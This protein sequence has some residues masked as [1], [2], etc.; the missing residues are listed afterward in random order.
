MDDGK[1]VFVGKKAL[2]P[3]FKRSSVIEP[4]LLQEQENHDNEIMAIHDSW[5]F[6]RQ[7]DVFFNNGQYDNAISSY[8]KALQASKGDES[9]FGMALIKAYEKMHRYDEALALLDEIESKYYKNEYGIQRAE[10]I[11]TRLT[12]AKGEFN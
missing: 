9:Y 5:A 6:A 4:K 1:G 12:T 7:G 11:R 2:N 10:E 8:K 3:N